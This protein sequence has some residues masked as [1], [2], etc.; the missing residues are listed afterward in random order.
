M[1]DSTERGVVANV[2]T[3]WPTYPLV[4]FLFPS[5][6][7]SRRMERESSARMLASRGEKRRIS[8][9]YLGSEADQTAFSRPISRGKNALPVRCEAGD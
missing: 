1:I 7:C 3:P 2:K 4:L 8:H 9:D 6:Y 5:P